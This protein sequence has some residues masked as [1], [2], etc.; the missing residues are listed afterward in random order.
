MDKHEENTV[1]TIQ[2]DEK[3]GQHHNAPGRKKEW[4]EKNRGK[5]DLERARLQQMLE[6][7]C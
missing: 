5:Q 2:D 3:K 6:R 7:S 1:L 4:N